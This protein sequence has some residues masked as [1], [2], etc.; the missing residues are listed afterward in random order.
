[1]AA[2]VGLAGVSNRGALAINDCRRTGAVKGS[3]TST[4]GQ[5]TEG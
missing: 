4:A 3:V 2:P 5:V 1:M